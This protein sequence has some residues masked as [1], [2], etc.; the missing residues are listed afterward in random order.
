M[1][2]ELSYPG[3]RVGLQNPSQDHPAWDKK[4]QRL[5]LFNH[6]EP[7]FAESTFFVFA[8]SKS[9]IAH[10]TRCRTQG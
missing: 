9:K 8:F 10:E 7:A 6:Q 3:V 5:S 2:L 1:E 4:G